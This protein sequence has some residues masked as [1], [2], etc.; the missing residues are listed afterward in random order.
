MEDTKAQSMPTYS[1]ENLS[2]TARFGG[3]S[4]I[5]KI[6]RAAEDTAK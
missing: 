3:A 1:M 4:T 2:K 5:N 6:S